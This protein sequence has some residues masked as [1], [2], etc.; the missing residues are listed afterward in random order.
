MDVHLVLKN[1][2]EERAGSIFLRSKDENKILFSRFQTQFDFKTISY[3]EEGVFDKVAAPLIEKKFLNDEDSLLLTLGPTNSGKTHL[4]FKNENSVLDQSL[5]L[6][7][8][9]IGQLSNNYNQIKKFYPDIENALTTDDTQCDT[10]IDSNLHFS[11]SMFELYND[12]II[13]LLTQNSKYDRANLGIVTDPV[14][15]KLTP[16][17]ISKFLINSYDKANEMISHG[18]RNRKTFSTFTNDSS[19]R[20]HCFIFFNLHK[21]YANVIQTTR[22]T[23]VDL[24]GLERS[25]SSRTTGLAL[26]EASYTNGSLTE[27]GRCLELISM[28]Q[29]HKTC[30]RTNK[31]TRLV[32]NDFVKFNHPVNIIVTLDPFG[33]E[34]LILQTLRYIDPIKYQDLQRKSLLSTNVNPRKA[35]AFEQQGLTNEI[36]RLRSK[37]K[38]LK[39]KV[40]TLESSIVENENRIRRELYEEN[41]K[42]LTRLIVSHKEEINNLSQSFINQTDK[43]LQDQSESY[44]KRIRDLNQ[45]IES[46]DTELTKSKEI[47]DEIKLELE[48][49]KSDYLDSTQQFE[50]FK[51]KS[52]EKIN[53]L[54]QIIEDTNVANESLKMQIE[55]LNLNI[56]ELECTQEESVKNLTD[57]KSLIIDGLERE[58]STARTSILEYT[59][60]LENYEKCLEDDKT[61][62]TEL[63]ELK[64]SLSNKI[65]DLLSN[66]NNHENKLK[67]LE[68]KL[69]S[70]NSSHLKSMELKET[71]ISNLNA[72][73]ENIRGSSKNEIE[74]LNYK[75][76]ELQ[77][78]NTTLLSENEV[79]SKNFDKNLEIK[80]QELLRAIKA[81][82][83]FRNDASL[84]IQ[85]L[86]KEITV[87]DHEFSEFTKNSNEAIKSLETSLSAKSE[88]GEKLKIEL[89]KSLATIDT[90]KE[91]IAAKDDKISSLFQESEKIKNE[92][93]NF[94]SSKY[95]ENDGNKALIDKNNEKII[96]LESTL[97][98]VKQS[99]DKEITDLHAKVQ[100]LEEKENHLKLNLDSQVVELEAALSSKKN[101]E[102]ELARLQML[103]SDLKSEMEF[104]QKFVEKYS[105]VKSKNSS[106][107]ELVSNLEAESK[108]LTIE[109]K[110]K[111]TALQN[112][113]SKIKTMTTKIE[114]LE[115]RGTERIKTLS[116]NEID[117]ALSLSFNGDQPINKTPR[118][119]LNILDTDPLDNFGLPGIMSSPLRAP[120]FKIHNDPIAE[121]DNTIT[122]GSTEHKRKVKAKKLSKQEQLFYQKENHEKKMLENYNIAESNK[123]NYKAL[124]NMKASDLNKRNSLPSN[125]KMK[126]KA[127]KR[128]SSSPLK[129]GQK[130]IRK[131]LGVEDSLEVLE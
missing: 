56:K 83:S 85:A 28:N 57:E 50:N 80:E 107:K 61:K 6:I 89:E 87:K 63:E 58:L 46:Q 112:A 94:K 123:K 30:L 5:R 119:S 74:N 90:L 41:E 127:K 101:L 108:K 109:V 31:L 78:I 18:L 40:E 17:N 64:T 81:M 16:R 22:F 45:I 75:V 4:L 97:K 113:A 34:G 125:P 70:V 33:E 111:D 103:C 42:N 76:N 13:D 105:L 114:A 69:E 92:F 55:A 37:Q 26:R 122:L 68:N 95:N 52:S 44:N 98:E 110:E 35:V 66:L 131:S 24:A 118:K 48:V 120:D 11:I 19:S 25:K 38:N 128:K 39:S 121:K 130:K 102:E 59:S 71:E 79:K 129:P 7:F 21:I 72:T 47:L 14:D 27:L 60:K 93:N 62:I 77:K 100:G 124:V 106:Y 99:K 8:S 96:S 116:S 91:Q 29:F 54:N 3:P 86:K 9:Q 20:S 82:N 23:I 1:N 10:S 32:L 67:E 115:K 73:L 126:L 117:T 65:S 12:N 15:G 43:K 36:N 84:E 2:P 53:Q 88:F 49:S 51:L 104:K